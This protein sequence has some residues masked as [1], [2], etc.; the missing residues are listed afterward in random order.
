VRCGFG[1]DTKQ[2][3]LTVLAH[4]ALPAVVLR[5]IGKFVVIEA[6]SAHSLIIEFEAKGL[7]KVQV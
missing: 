4:E 3:I 1:A 2:S 5:N 7:Y 6:G